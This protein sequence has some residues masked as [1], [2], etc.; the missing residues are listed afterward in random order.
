MSD[1]KWTIDPTREGL[2]RTIEQMS[3]GVILED[4]SGC[5]IYANKRIIEWSGYRVDELEGQHVN[6]TVPT[7]LHEALDAERALAHEGDQRT[8]L[9][10]FQ[11]KDGRTFPVAVLPQ[12]ITTEDGER[13]VFALLVDLGEVQTARPLGADSG[14]LAA[15]LAGIASRLNAMSYTATVTDTTVA[16]V[17]QKLLDELSE[18]EREV[19]ARLVAGSRVPVISEELF[20]SANTVRNHLKAIYRKLDVASQSE[21]IEL[22]RCHGPYRIH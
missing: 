14:S 15:E 13:A 20:I 8:R 16:R 3:G 22:V 10:V 12:L 7:E 17:D 4:Q 9:S 6:I 18:R 11:R 2:L 21:L 19:L 5:I 1:W